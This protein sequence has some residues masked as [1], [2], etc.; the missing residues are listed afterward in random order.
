MHIHTFIAVRTEREC[1]HLWNAHLYFHFPSTYSSWYVYHV[2]KLYSLI[3]QVS[4]QVCVCVCVPMC[5]WHLQCRAKWACLYLQPA[6]FLSVPPAYPPDP[7]E[8][9]QLGTS[10]GNCP[11]GGI[12]GQVG[13]VKR[14]EHA[15]L[16]RLLAHSTDHL[17]LTLLNQHAIVDACRAGWRV[18][19]WVWSPPELSPGIALFLQLM[20][21]FYFT[22]I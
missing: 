15:C 9:A 14:G 19:T 3:K 4:I 17:N 11:Q 22:F 18:V 5:K 1:W 13:G 2:H 8:H 7:T 10:H 20:F 16:S 12:T 6:M 21:L